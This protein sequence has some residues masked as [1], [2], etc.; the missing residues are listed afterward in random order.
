MADEHKDE[1]IAAALQEIQALEDKGTWKEV[2]ITEA[3]TKVLPGTWV[4]RVKRR[5]DGSILKRKMRYCVRGDLQEGEVDSHSQVAAWSS[6]RLF[7]VLCLTLGWYT[8][9]CD[10]SNAFVQATLKSPIW[11]HLPRGFRASKSQ[12]GCKT[13][14][15][16]IK[17]LYGI[18]EAPKLWQEFLASALVNDMG[19]NRST[20]DRCVFYKDGVLL[21][22]Y[23]DDVCVG[24]RTKAE[25]DAF[26]EQLRS[27]KFDFTTEESITSYLGIKFEEDEANGSFDLTQPG[28]IDKV[29]E[30]C[31]MEDCNPNKTPAAR[32]TLGKD[33]EGEAFTGPWNYRSVCGMLLYL[34]TN[35][36]PDIAF[37]VSQVCRFTHD[38]KQSHAR[39]VKM[40]VRYLKGTKNQG[41]LVQPAGQLNLE[42]YCDAD[43]AGLYGSETADDSNSARSRMGYIIKLGG[44]P[45]VWK[46]QLITEITL[47]TAESEYASLSNCMRTLIPLRRLLLE[48]VQG[49]SLPQPQASTVSARVFEDNNSALQLAVK[50]RV[51]N[52][53]RHY[54]VKWHHFWSCVK[55]EDGEEPEILVLRVDTKLQ[56]ADYLTKGLP[57]ETFEANRLRVQGW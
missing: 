41:T 8:C 47:S 16:L 13:V 9:C 55:P 30:A 50:Q 15:Q 24:A 6:I 48:L 7:L 21:V 10:F 11:I 42:A 51:T 22:Q 52:R 46:S 2:P 27:L 53:T 36:R 20:I 54:Q 23:V 38:P 35:T 40:I 3:Q 44:C 19:F 39:A 34:S 57:R 49:L 25:A 4:G 28:L 1:W 56:D 17:S 14:L 12:T 5:P 29:V 31:G 37:A 43:F 26:F 18:S 32:T 45:I 33:P